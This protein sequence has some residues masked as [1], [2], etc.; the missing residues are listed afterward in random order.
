MQMASTLVLP[1]I[2]WWWRADLS[3]VVAWR[4]D[5]METTYSRAP[6]LATY[7]VPW[8]GEGARPPQA[9]TP[10]TLPMFALWEE[11]ARTRPC[12]RLAQ[13]PGLLSLPVA[14]AARIFQQWRRQQTLLLPEHRERDLR[15][16]RW[17]HY[18]GKSTHLFQVHGLA[19]PVGEVALSPFMSHREL[20]ERMAVAPSREW[21]V[22]NGLGPC[23]AFRSPQGG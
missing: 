18:T 8:L 4:M 12:L 7:L 2:A 5:E 1:L 9:R 16:Q 20:L 23:G 3:L 13:V 21:T 15:A 14:V 6:A 22:A 17:A 10:L 11:V 19:G